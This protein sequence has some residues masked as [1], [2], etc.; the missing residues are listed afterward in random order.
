MTAVATP[1]DVWNVAASGAWS[2]AANWSLH[3]APTSGDNVDI[4]ASS[5]FTVTM[6]VGNFGFQGLTLIGAT[7][8]LEGGYLAAYGAADLQNSS[9]VGV[10]ALALIDGGAVSGLTVGGAVNL[11]NYKQVT[12]SGGAVTIGDS[13]TSTARIY[14]LSGATWTITDA[15]GISWDGQSGWGFFNA[16]TFQKTSGSGTA[17]I[18]ANFVSTGTIS[19]AG[20]GDIEFDGRASLSGTYVGAGMVD[21]GPDGAAFVGNVQVTNS[22]CQTNWGTVY[23]TADM[24][25]YD[26]STIMNAA[27]ARWEFDGDASLLLAAGQAAGPDINGMGL[28]A[29]IAGT[30]VSQVGIDVATEGVVWVTT[31]TLDFDGA[32]SAFSST[33]GG[34]GTFE[35]GGGAATIQSGVRLS[36]ANWTLAG[37]TT[38]LGENVSYAGAFT[39][40]AGATLDLNYDTL[41][42][43]GTPTLSGLT[44]DGGGF[45]SLSEGADITGLTVSSA[46]VKQTAGQTVLGDS[47]PT[48]LAS[49]AIGNGGDWDLDGASGFSLGAD[50]A[51]AIA[52]DAGANPGTLYKSGT[53]LSVVAPNVANNGVN[54][55]SGSSGFVPR[56]IVV[57]A[58]TLDLKGGLSGTGTETIDGTG[59]TNNLT[60]TTLQFDGAVA[61]GQTIDFFGAGA[62]LFVNDLPAFQGAI[63][64][65]DGAGTDSIL[66]GGGYVFMGATEGATSTTLSFL[67]GPGQTALTLTLAG[68]YLGDK[69]AA[70]SAGA[71][72]IR[73]V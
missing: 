72:V 19:S 49:L 9:L 45:L 16:G 24:T 27:G 44:V 8:D 30:G 11:Y 65:F 28:I 29:K 67:Q 2:V 50:P 20:G 31:G 41:T 7:L 22:S 52:I 35:I 64:G 42:L 57:E 60:E 47:S 3:H 25:M 46:S 6:D 59:S 55:P 36:V 70:T 26:G 48:D 33:V 14:N 21:Y 54:I 12:Q 5:P 4:E 10:R 43:T 68:D 23:L 34:A 53:G 61:A 15:S 71:G 1:T 63:A 73:V 40:E 37:G 18:K 13:S 17:L 62:A 32:S 69:F 51:S 56:G 66:V 39:G 58:G 38:T